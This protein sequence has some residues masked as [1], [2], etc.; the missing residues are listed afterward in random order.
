[1]TVALF[2]LAAAAIVALWNRFFERVPWRI[3]ILLWL[4]CAG[5]QSQ[6]L[7]SSRVDLPGA[8]A[9]RVYPWR[10]LERPAPN[11]NTGIVFTQIAPWTRVARDAVL[12]GE[13]PL[14]NRNAASGAPL[15]ANQQTAIF[16][17]FT[18][19]GLLLPIGKA[20]TLSA[21]LRLFAV[22]FFMF[23]F[24]RNLGIGTPASIFGTIAYTF[25]TFHVVWLLFPLGLATMMMPACLAGAQEVARKP[26]P[27]SYALL[28]IALSCCVLGGHPESALWVWIVTAAFVLYSRQHV[29]L[30]GSAFIVAMLLTAFFWFPTLRALQSSDRF[31]SM[32]S[33]ELNPTNHHLSAEWLLTLV[34]PNAL[35]TPMRGDYHPPRGRH[36][37]VLNDYGEVAS[38]YAGLLT[39]ACALATP[40]VA[41][42]RPLW[43]ALGLM[44][45]ALLTIAEA[46]LWRDALRAVPLAGISLHQRLRIVWVLGVCIAAALTVDR[47]PRL[48]PLFTLVVFADLLLTTRHYNPPSK[49]RDIYPVT[50]AIAALQRAPQPFRFA[51]LGWSFLPDT[52]SYYGIEDVKTTDPI[53]KTEYMRL[54][55]GY[56]RIDPA[57]PDLIIGDTSQ[58]FFD[59]LNIRYVYTPP[60]T[61]LSDPKFI[62]R[63]RGTDGALYENT[64]AL[65]R[66]F[67]VKSYR[68]EGDFDRALWFSRDIRDFR[69]EAIVDHVPPR[70]QTPIGS[71]EA[72][73][74]RYAGSETELDVTS[75]GWSLL[76]SSDE[77]WRGWRAYWNGRRIPVVTVNG[78]FLGSFAP[79]GRGRLRF[80]YMPDEFMWGM[81]VSLAA[82]IGCLIAG[83]AAVRRS[84]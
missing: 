12:R 73:I 46:P 55:R 45:F 2:A 20:F 44:L 17:P 32:Q 38:G 57:S 4:I 28:V 1:M 69:S 40:F 59:F 81:R 14:W 84:R 43:F 36:A 61:V 72:H 74:V 50:G 9:Y 18:L 3:A 62:E 7:F 68:V 27:A 54:L 75:T 25:C 65:P 21:S 37:T 8:L 60:G 13:M 35:G 47:I 56:L 67:F 83:F 41:R 33:R 80:R 5:Y 64:H 39:L 63:Y 66:Y 24:L 29:I 16:H 48:A 76:A 82:L 22:A 19:L 11:A 78:T 10:A 30:P 70:V 15:L 71:G 52:P 53:H 6:T 26:R 23:V 42:K 31:Q 49:P 58:P 79:P 77:H 51:A 34:A